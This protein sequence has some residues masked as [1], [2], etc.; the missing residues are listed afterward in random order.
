M[1]ARMRAKRRLRADSTTPRLLSQPLRQITGLP[2]VVLLVQAL[3]IV[4]SLL[5][6]HD[7]IHGSF[8]RFWVYFV[9]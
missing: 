7:A 5:L 8:R 3:F 6:L 2:V 1:G 4:P 9:W